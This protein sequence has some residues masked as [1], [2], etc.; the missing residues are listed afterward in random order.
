MTLKWA[1]TQLHGPRPG[2]RHRSCCAQSIQ[3]PG[4]GVGQVESDSFIFFFYKFNISSVFSIKDALFS[5]NSSRL[6]SQTPKHGAVGSLGCALRVRLYELRT[7]AFP[8]AIV[9][10]CRV[11]ILRHWHW[12]PRKMYLNYVI[13]PAWVMMSSHNIARILPI[14]RITDKSSR[15]I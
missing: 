4:M 9:G 12:L 11:E 8:G 15:K 5:N 14:M 2:P 3:A 13:V 1:Q 10:K 7:Q 6:H